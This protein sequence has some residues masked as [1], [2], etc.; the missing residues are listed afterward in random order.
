[1]NDILQRNIDKHIPT[2]VKRVKGRKS[3]W[4]ITEQR[5]EMYLSDVLHRKFLESKTTT[6]SNAYKAQR[7]HTNVLVRKA[8]KTTQSESFK[9]I[10]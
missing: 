4:F 9:R 10:C 6:D 3:A 1:M 7:N 5:S 8:K 2:I